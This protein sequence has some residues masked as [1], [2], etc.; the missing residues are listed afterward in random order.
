MPNPDR[1]YPYKTQIKQCLFQN[2][3]TRQWC[4]YNDTGYIQINK[5]ITQKAQSIFFSEEK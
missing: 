5:N 3:D 4:Y 2:T 1:N